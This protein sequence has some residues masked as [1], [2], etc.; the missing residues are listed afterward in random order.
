MFWI[1]VAL[2]A[3]TLAVTA[4]GAYKLRAAR[5][6]VARCREWTPVTGRVIT[7]SI[8]EVVNADVGN[9]YIPVV[10]YRYVVGDMQYQGEQLAIGG[11]TQYAR[12]RNAERRLDR[13]VSGE[14]VQVY[15]DPANPLNAVL[16]C[17]APVVSVLWT[18]LV[19]IWVVMIAGLGMLLLTPGVV[20]P[21]AILRW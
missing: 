1:V 13:Y 15:V 14:P 20:G 6:A 7:R 17:R 10:V 3:L 8:R 4:L 11:H 19:L 12:R 2:I 18:M 9:Q 21:D 16:E 5:L